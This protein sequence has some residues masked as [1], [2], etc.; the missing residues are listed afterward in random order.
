MEKPKGKVVAGWYTAPEVEGYEQY[1]DGSKWLKQKRLIGSSDEF[2]ESHDF[3]VA[4]RNGFNKV[5]D[6]KSRAKRFEYWYFLLFYYVG[7]FVGSVILV[8]MRLEELINL[9]FLSCAVCLVSLSVRRMHD[10]GKSGWFILIP[11]YSLYLYCQPTKE[12]VQ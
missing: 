2:R 5:F 1:W 6:Y 10:V 9:L 7:T 11:I 4:V 3:V 12:Q 8:G